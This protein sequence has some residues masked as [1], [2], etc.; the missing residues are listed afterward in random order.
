[1]T[2]LLQSLRDELVRRDYTDPT[3]RS[4]IQIVEAFPTGERQAHQVLTSVAFQWSCK[5]AASRQ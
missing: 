4:Y 2:K 3:I 1:M 5:N